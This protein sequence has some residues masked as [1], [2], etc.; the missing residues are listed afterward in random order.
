MMVPLSC[1]LILMLSSAAD[2]GTMHSGL[3]RSQTLPVM[4]KTENNLGLD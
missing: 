1:S 4:K 3:K 2:K